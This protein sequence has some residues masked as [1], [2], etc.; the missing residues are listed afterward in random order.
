[1]SK[2][3]TVAVIGS[4]SFSGSVTVNELLR[5]GFNVVGINRS[6]ESENCYRAYRNVSLTNFHFHQLGSNFDSRRL[7]EILERYNVKEVI[8]FA[9]QSMVAESWQS[10]WD[11]Y[12][13]NIVWLS[14][15]TTALIGYDKLKK[16]IHFSTP[17]V[18]GTTANWVQENRNFMPSTP[19][20]IS[21]L[22][23]DLH[24]ECEM[25][26]AS[27][28][29]VF[30]RAANVYG[31]FQARYRLIPKALI[32]AAQRL[33]FQIDGEGDS[34]R[35][36]IY[37]EDVA[38]ALLSILD[39]GRIG[40]CYHIST[41]TTHTIHEIVKICY[42]RFG[43]N[44]NDFI[45]HTSERAGKD[46]AYLLAS[47]KLREELNWREEVKLEEGIE[48]TKRWV[49]TDLADILSQSEKYLHRA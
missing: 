32:C 40:D 34:R 7:V 25:E 48:R 45:V 44:A 1:M 28:P 43:L 3:R 14:K 11:W 22:A 26:R 19:Y 31:P 46:S 21:R 2:E 12:E 23:G 4:N 30:T 24:L 41:E 49:L 17:E 20:A 9:S 8:N 37:M 38:K 15:L 16:F 39:E 13:T 33:P 29:V 6:P 42:S 18:Y 47:K 35:S 5:C 10:P 36:F 27:F